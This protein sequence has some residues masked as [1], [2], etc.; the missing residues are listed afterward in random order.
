MASTTTSPV[1]ARLDQRPGTYVPDDA[2]LAVPA[3][4]T[5]STPVT[6]AACSIRCQKTWT[7]STRLPKL[8]RTRMKYATSGPEQHQGEHDHREVDHQ[9]QRRGTPMLKLTVAV[10]RARHAPCQGGAVHCSAVRAA[11][12]TNRPGA[13]RPSPLRSP[14]L[15]NQAAAPGDRTLRLDAHVRI[16]RPSTLQSRPKS[17]QVNVGACGA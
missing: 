13:G 10:R 14:P 11:P 6:D 8:D 3:W 4:S 15:G 16:R 2:L 9:L 5:N 17:H 1:Q 7:T 12:P